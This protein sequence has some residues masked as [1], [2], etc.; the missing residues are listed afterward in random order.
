MTPRS[1]QTEYRVVKQQPSIISSMDKTSPKTLHHFVHG[2]NV[3]PKPSVISSMDETLSQNSPSFHAW[4][5]CLS[6]IFSLFGFRLLTVN[7]SLLYSDLFT[8]SLTPNPVH[9]CTILYRHTLLQN[10]SKCAPLTST[11]F[12]GIGFICEFLIFLPRCV[13]VLVNR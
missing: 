6:K 1:N 11:T 8:D 12:V 5:K 3:S 4:T 10:L 7:Y 13:S 2:Q 9:V